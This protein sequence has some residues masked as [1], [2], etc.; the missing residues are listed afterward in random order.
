MLFDTIED[1]TP[2]ADHS[3][4]LAGER[5]RAGFIR[6]HYEPEHL[7]I[8]DCAFQARTSVNAVFI[9]WPICE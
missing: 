9:T 2:G 1:A 3:A 4:V 5:R 7:P 8:F 6:R